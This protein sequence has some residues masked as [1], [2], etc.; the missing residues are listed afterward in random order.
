MPFDSTQSD[1]PVASERRFQTLRELATSSVV[2]V[3][4]RNVVAAQ[5]ATQ[6][7]LELNPGEALRRWSD[8]ESYLLECRAFGVDSCKKLRI[9]LKQQVA[10][11]WNNIGTPGYSITESDSGHLT[12]RD[13]LTSD[14]VPIRIQNAIR[15]QRPDTKLLELTP[16]EALRRWPDVESYLLECKALG[17]GSC[18]HVLRALRDHVGASVP[19][20]ERPLIHYLLSIESGV[21]DS[22]RNVIAGFDGH[23]PLNQLTIAQA[24]SHFPVLRFHL[25]EQRSLGMARIAQFEQ[26]LRLLA[27][28]EIPCTSSDP[29]A[30]VKLGEFVRSRRISGRINSVFRNL[31]K[32]NPVAMLTLQ[33]GLENW[34]SVETYLRTRPNFGATSSHALRVALEAEV[35]LTSKMP[36]GAGELEDGL[37]ALT[38][39][40][41]KHPLAA[42]R[43]CCLLGLLGSRESREQFANLLEQTTLLDI[44]RQPELFAGSKKSWFPDMVAAFL[45]ETADW[46]SKSADGQLRLS[47]TGLAHL[48]QWCLERNEHLC[49]EWVTIQI[50]VKS[51]GVRRASK[52]LDLKHAKQS[53]GDLLLR[54][55]SGTALHWEN[56]RKQIVQ[57][58]AI[59]GLLNG[60]GTDPLNAP[61]NTPSTEEVFDLLLMGLSDRHREMVLARFAP[62][63]R[64]PMTL[65]DAGEMFNV[66]RERI[67][68][69]T[70]KWRNTI[71]ED[72]RAEL[73]AGLVASEEQTW[74]D[75]LES[76]ATFLSD[77]SSHDCI[78]ALLPQTA[79]LIL[80]ASGDDP[81]NWVRRN[82]VVVDGV[83]HFIRPDDTRIRDAETFLRNF[84]LQEPILPRLTTRI[85]GAPDHLA[86]SIHS[87]SIIKSGRLAA[88]MTPAGI[89][90]AKD[91]SARSRRTAFVLAVFEEHPD[92][93]LSDQQLWNAICH[94][95]QN[96]SARGQWRIFTDS[97]RSSPWRFRRIPR[98][99]W[100]D[101]IDCELSGEYRPKHRPLLTPRVTMGSRS[102]AMGDENQRGNLYRLISA[103]GGVYS[104]ECIELW[105][106][107][108]GSSDG[109]AVGF[110]LEDPFFVISHPGFTSCLDDDGVLVNE[111][112]IR[113]RLRTSEALETYLRLRWAGFVPLEFPAWNE[114]LLDAWR[115]WTE[116]SIREDAADVIVSQLQKDISLCQDVRTGKTSGLNPVSDFGL[117]DSPRR[118][119]DSTIP[120]MEDVFLLIA[121]GA[122]FGFLNWYLVNC[123]TGSHWY[124]HRSISCLGFLIASGLIDGAKH[125]QQQHFLTEAGRDILYEL[126][127]AAKHCDS[128][129][130]STNRLGEQLLAKTADCWQDNIEGTWV[131]R[132]EFSRLLAAMLDPVRREGS[133]TLNADV[134]KLA[135]SRRALPLKSEVRATQYVDQFLHDLLD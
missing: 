35:P 111:R 126:L 12:L 7:L 42:H 116:A 72:G 48:A 112:A 86:K 65:Q 134:F 122:R 93:I 57:T 44:V 64:Y 108:D 36:H 37:T 22:V 106:N 1:K 25:M 3:R 91:R 46:F 125:W 98:I 95:S 84:I 110:L 133:A 107:H 68:Q 29:I 109:R 80:H 28:I 114:D 76:S 89:A 43:G 63:T 75:A 16:C 131:R 118:P 21:V 20:G 81:G 77:P 67:R 40:A 71:E 17:V 9:A 94:L 14:V 39:D 78:A 18:E 128:L 92:W 49:V 62:T 27:S 5:P 69:I 56:N 54:F 97:I 121:T 31:P 113:E 59:T 8:V 104:K 115:E 53:E 33:Q 66:T 30:D 101:L 87:T 55:A 82:A 119:V 47:M 50:L 24:V 73:A 60:V 83:C 127:E 105:A 34:G 61:D 58:S 79:K 23:H 103:R 124:S 74:L 6:E 129:H 85:P 15:A 19:F 100:L 88:I 117:S 51:I 96:Q 90:I 123:C 32:S 120:S 99:G 130:W 102:E 4:V 11:H 70:Q 135:S 52:L 38:N 26:Q 2:P 13:L 41:A 45:F 132:V 10:V